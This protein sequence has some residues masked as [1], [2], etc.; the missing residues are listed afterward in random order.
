MYGRR[1][2]ASAPRSGASSTCPC[3]T[4]SCLPARVKSFPSALRTLAPE[5]R[6]PWSRQGAQGVQI[7]FDEL[8]LGIQLER[9]VPQLARLLVARGAV[10]EIAEVLGEL[11]QRRLVLQRRPRERLGL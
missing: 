9:A 4:R 2:R 3:T 5:E 11:R 1:G 6:P 10:G 7:R 8:V